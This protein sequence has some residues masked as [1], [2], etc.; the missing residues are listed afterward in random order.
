MGNSTISDIP[1]PGAKLLVEKCTE[2]VNLIEKDW[3]GD[4][5]VIQPHPIA[6]IIRCSSI[7]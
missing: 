5:Q 7:Q 4:L 2:D 1:L 3:V 6:L